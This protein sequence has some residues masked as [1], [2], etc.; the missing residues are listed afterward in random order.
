MVA[1]E[2]EVQG[3]EGGVVVDGDSL[4]G[5]LPDFVA[6]ADLTADF[7]QVVDCIGDVMG[8]EGRAI[9]PLHLRP[10]GDGQLGEVVVVV[11]AFGLPH[12]RLV[13]EGVPVGHAFIDDV[14]AALVVAADGKGC[15]DF[16][17]FKLIAAPPA[18]DQRP[19]SGNIFD[20]FH[21]G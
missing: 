19:L 11:K 5:V 3:D 9:A 1:G 18:D 12:D 14:E 7:D 13:S 2:G 6:E 21:T 4:F 17:L 10:Q 8:S 15:V 20:A 16:R